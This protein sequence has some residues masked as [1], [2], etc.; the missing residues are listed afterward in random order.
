MLPLDIQDVSAVL[1]AAKAQRDERQQS[2]RDSELAIRRALDLERQR[3]EE[4]DAMTDDEQDLE[5]AA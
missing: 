2:D 1:E 4:A 3:Q 5:D